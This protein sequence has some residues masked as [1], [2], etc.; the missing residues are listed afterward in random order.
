MPAKQLLERVL[1]SQFEMIFTRLDELEMTALEYR[2]FIEGMVRD[3]CPYQDFLDNAREAFSADPKLLK[4]ICTLRAFAMADEAALIFLRQHAE[5]VDV[6]RVNAIV[7]Q[8]LLEKAL[9]LKIVPKVDGVQPSDLSVK[10]HAL[11]EI[12]VR[13]QEEA[14][15]DVFSDSE[16][17]MS[18]SQGPLSE[19]KATLKQF[20]EEPDQ[21]QKL[22]F[23]KQV[24]ALLARCQ[25]AKLYNLGG[26]DFSN[27]NLSG[28]DLSYMDFSDAVVVNVDFS[29]SQ[30]L[31]ASFRGTDRVNR[32]EVIA[33]FSGANC[34]QMDCAAC[35]LRQSTFDV[36]TRVDEMG[37]A[38]SR[39]NRRNLITL[40]PNA[41]WWT[42]Q[43]NG[44]PRLDLSNTSFEDEDLSNMDLSGLY[45]GK[46]Y[47]RGANLSGTEFGDSDVRG[48]DFK[49]AKGFLLSGL[50]R[51]ANKDAIQFTE[52][53]VQKRR[54]EGAGSSGKITDFF[55]SGVRAAKQA[56]HASA[57]EG[58]TDIPLP[59]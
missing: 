28:L 46:V 30:L 12:R 57:Q 29:G 26:H 49:K 44:R 58:V 33:D 23:Q 5:V 4:T 1:H 37:L 40:L 20:H 54:S 52:T 34:A 18:A 13:V 36:K 24:R 47:F 15:A 51:C 32:H 6:L 10:L 48:A 35:D 25:Q 21:D 38:S 3:Q 31:A 27:L 7:S 14:R 22:I 45:L 39:L 50:S 53:R 9:S 2:A 59:G 43:E 8:V 11:F 19:L 56:R 41:Q 42:V 17:S 16:E 55:G